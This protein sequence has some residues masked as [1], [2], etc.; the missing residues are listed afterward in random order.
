MLSEASNEVL[1]L[2]CGV[3]AKLGDNI[4]DTMH[5]AG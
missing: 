1:V 3:A 4:V 2:N 5:D